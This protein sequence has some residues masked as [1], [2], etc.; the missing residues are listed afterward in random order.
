MTSRDESTAE[1]AHGDD[2]LPEWQDMEYEAQVPPPDWTSGP[3]TFDD[4]P[5]PQIVRTVNLLPIPKH[6]VASA[7]KVEDI[8]AFILARAQEGLGDIFEHEDYAG[9][10]GPTERWAR[11]IAE[12]QTGAPYTQPVYFYRNQKKVV[13]EIV[14]RGRYPLV[15]QCQ[16]SVTTAL[17][18]GGWDGGVAGD[19]GSGCSAFS[20]CGRLGEGWAASD[21]PPAKQTGG[22]VNHEL[23]DW[24][25]DLWNRIGVGSCLF[26]AKEGDEGQGH[27][28]LVIRKHPTERRWQLWDTR[29][30]FLEPRVTAAAAQSR[31]LWESPWWRRIPVTM[32]EGTWA[33]HGIAR[34]GGLGGVK[35]ALKPR[36]LCRLVLRGRKDQRLLYRSAWLS[37]EEHG[38]P[39]SWLLRSL[40]GAPFHDQIEPMWCINAEAPD[41]R[42]LFDCTCDE[43]G[44]A[45]MSWSP[46]QGVHARPDPAA[47]APDAPYPAGASAP[48][49]KAAAA[50]SSPSSPAAAGNT[51]R[52][53]A[54]T[55]SGGLKSTELAGQAELEQ[56]VAAGKGSVA[57]GAQGPMVKAL[58]EA[59]LSLGYNLGAAGADGDFGKGTTSAV[60]QFQKDAHLSVDGVVG[61]GVLKALDRA[62]SNRGGTAS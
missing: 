24:P 23:S 58:Q 47:W 33:F 38:L 14:E 52:G 53:K 5:P 48:S 1:T 29:T 13:R 20:A 51:E 30:S 11:A 15:G 42:P 57:R 9:F 18:L 39:A 44:N 35:P 55:G 10:D 6:D 8:A 50:A 22:A 7:D 49:Q 17:C 4:T 26:W 60:Q 19:I 59:L 16:Q 28:A 43:R 34:I 45:K 37:M 54:A 12:H 36:G 40:R 31:M 56:I 21:L 2:A 3:A 62:L 27:V 61:P 32:S 25:D 41:K 46:N